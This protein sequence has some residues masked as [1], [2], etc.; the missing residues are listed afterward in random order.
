M[1]TSR[2]LRLALNTIFSLAAALAVLAARGD[3][4]T[5]PVYSVTDMGPLIFGNV[6]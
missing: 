3:A 5:P 2:I 6:Y 4:A 1:K